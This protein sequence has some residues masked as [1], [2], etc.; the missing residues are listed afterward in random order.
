[1]SKRNPF[2]EKIYRKKVFTEG[3]RVLSYF[4]KEDEVKQDELLKELFG[5]VASDTKSLFIQ[6]IWLA[7]VLYRIRRDYSVYIRSIKRRETFCRLMTTKEDFEFILNRI[8]ERIDSLNAEK[9]RVKD[10][11][12]DIPAYNRKVRALIETIR[13]K[14]EK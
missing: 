4:I 9:S 3:L 6:K 8:D 13:E 5:K 2:L 12:T 1:M 10:I 7:G 14:L 11:L